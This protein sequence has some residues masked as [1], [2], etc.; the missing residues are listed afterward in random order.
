MYNYIKI[1]TFI[2][3]VL[4]LSFLIGGLVSYFYAKESKVWQAFPTLYTFFPALVALFVMWYFKESITLPN[5]GLTFS[6]NW[7][8]YLLAMLL[9]VIYL[10]LNNIIQLK[11]GNYMLKNDLN[12]TEIVVAVIANQFV[13]LLFIAGEELGWRSFLQNRLIE[14][15]GIWTAV[16]ILGIVWG[17]WH[18]PIALKGYNLPNHPKFEAFVFYPFV[19]ICYSAVMVF[20]TYK[21][22]SIIPAIL[23]H[24]TN[25][26]LGGLSLLLFD[27]K[28]QT[29]E[30]IV[31]FIIGFLMLTI[32]YFLI[33]DIKKIEFHSQTLEHLDVITL[34][35]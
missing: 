34:K 16:F 11:L 12:I 3:I 24:T 2:S 1:W 32:S 26:N 25:N 4:C 33:N 22:Q 29:S 13:L 23:F 10:G 19:C 20:L 27:K 18:A 31:Y 6:G 15:Y 9:P 21:T 28:N 17:L 14:E 8:F 5:L 35:E 30:M 7:K